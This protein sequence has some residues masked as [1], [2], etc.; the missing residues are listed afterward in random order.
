MSVVS[1]DVK[2]QR[3]VHRREKHHVEQQQ[4]LSLSLSLTA[5]SDVINFNS[6][7]NQAN[8]APSN[9]T[10]FFVGGLIFLHPLF[11]RC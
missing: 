3:V 11:A 6:S 2:A 7:R 8:Q 1:A 4:P 5:G 9:A 10:D